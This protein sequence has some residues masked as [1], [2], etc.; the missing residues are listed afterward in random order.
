V[1]FYSS[2]YP[3]SGACQEESIS[4]W[5]AVQH[6]G[7]PPQ[8]RVCIINPE[9]AFDHI[10]A[11]LRDIKAY[12]LPN[13]PAGLAALAA[14]LRTH[15]DSL[16]DGLSAAAQLVLPDYHG[17]VPVHARHFV[18]RVHELWE[19]HGRL[20]GNRIGLISGIYGQGTAQIR[21]LGGNGKSLL[22]R[23]YALRFG[24]AYPGGVF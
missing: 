3:L 8:G 4:A 6:A 24:P 13:D 21:G 18:G 20:T 19:L 10:P 16:E 5:L 22:A 12:A 2:T 7:E 15:A 14:E 1:A 17:M 11:P 9:P 23:E